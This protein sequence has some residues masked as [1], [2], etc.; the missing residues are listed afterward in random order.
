MSAARSTR[1]EQQGPQQKVL[2]SSGEVE[3]TSE[4]ANSHNDGNRI[5]D[6]LLCRWI[7]KYLH[8]VLPF[9]AGDA[10]ATVIMSTR[11]YTFARGTAVSAVAKSLKDTFAKT[12]ID[13]AK[14]EL[15]GD[16]GL[17]QVIKLV[18][19]PD[20]FGERDFDSVADTMTISP[21]EFEL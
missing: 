16:D 1:A 17:E 4:D 14:V 18:N 9:N 3:A 7:G 5:D 12:E 15:I 13:G 20:F 10:R 19:T 6:C 8:L 2:C 21:M 11:R